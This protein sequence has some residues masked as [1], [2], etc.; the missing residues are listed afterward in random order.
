MS[1]SKIVSELQSLS[2]SA[3]IELFELQLK[4]DLHGS[5]D[6]YYFH[7]GSSLNLNGKIKWNGK[8]YLRFP[9][10]AT[11]FEY[12]G[13]KLPRPELIISNATG[14]MTALLLQVNQ[15]TVGNDLIGAI[16]TRKR[17]LAKFLP[18]DNFI[19]NNPS[20]A[21][22]ENAEFPREIYTVARKSSENREFV[23]FELAAP[24]D[25]ENIN[26]PKRICTRKNFP[27]IGTF[28]Q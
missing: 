9:V 6:I 18:N 19:G 14:L 24:L 1:S 26:A 8:D 25:L 5:S 12:T 16:F 2:P 28:I 10:E 15:V 20:G 11:G 22:D 4:N 13:G 3:V 7:S 17:T 21:V 27:S 23:R